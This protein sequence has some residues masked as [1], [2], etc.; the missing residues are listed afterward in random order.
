MTHD[1]QLIELPEDAAADG[2]FGWALASRVDLAKV[3]SREFYGHD[4]WPITVQEFIGMRDHTRRSER[5]PG[6]V[7]VDPANPTRVVAKGW[8]YLTLLDNLN[9]LDFEVVVH[10]EHRRRGLGTQILQWFEA[11]A[12]QEQRTTLSSWFDIKLSREVQ[13][14]VTAPD[15]G[16]FDASHLGWQFAS[17]RGWSLEQIERASVLDV[18]VASELLDEIMRESTP[19]AKGYRVV[20]WRGAIPTQWRQGFID[21][22]RAMSTDAPQGG[23]EHDAEVWDE[24]RLADEEAMAVAMGRVRLMCAAV[25]EGTGELAGFTELSCPV[26]PTRHVFQWNTI[27][28][29]AHRGHRL[30]ALIK[31]TNLAELQ[32]VR[33]QTT[34][35]YTW[36]AVQNSYM[37]AIN[38]RL[39]FRPE[40]GAATVQKKLV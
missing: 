22:Q 32:R 8:G 14:Q 25:H 13:P 18:P 7:M 10:P 12:R 37:L 28:A 26:Q 4:D 17:K 6:V 39:G 9:R 34:R 20:T 31:A 24:K 40:G 38:I 15:G 5:Q 3:V 2:P 11:L 30:G 33:P 21:L 27:I 1:Y 19:Q 36:N 23:L 29:S 16:S 35:V